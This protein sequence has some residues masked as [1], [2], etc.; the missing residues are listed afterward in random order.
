MVAHT[1]SIFPCSTGNTLLGKFGQKKKIKTE[2]NGA[3][4]FFCFI[5]ETPVL[6]KFD[7][8]IKIVSLSWN[9]ALRLIRICRIQWGA[10]FFCLGRETPFLDKC[11]SKNQN[12][13]FKL[14]FGT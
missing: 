11:G 8:K 10:H 14:K 9:L 12:F 5:P 1:T 4:H 3:V 13:Q 6:G 7:Q 2:F